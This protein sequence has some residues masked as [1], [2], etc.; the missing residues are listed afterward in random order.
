[1]K[2][3]TIRCPPSSDIVT[4]RPACKGSPGCLRGNS[5]LCFLPKPRIAYGRSR[6]CGGRVMTASIGSSA[7]SAPPSGW[8]ALFGKEDWWAIW[9]GLGHR[10][11]QQ[12]PV[13]ERY[14]SPVAGRAA[15]QMVELLANRCRSRPPTGRAIL[16]NSCSG[17]P[18][19]RWP[20][21]RL[22]TRRASSCRPSHCFMSRPMRSSCWA[23]GE[24]AAAYSLEPPLIALFAGPRH[25]QHGGPPTLAGCRLPGVSF[26]SR[27]ASC[28]LAP[29]CLSR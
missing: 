6:L 3:R 7:G 28:C 26:T 18:P 21:A 19:S 10:A 15:A 9:I 5:C 23:S 2:S 14:Q 29:R 11:R 25:R 17:L 8:R 27:P 1:M 4:S 13:L 16:R 12:H 20:C 22:A 24:G